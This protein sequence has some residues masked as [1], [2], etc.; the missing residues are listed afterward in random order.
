MV[1]A[2]ADPRLPA[3]SRRAS[4]VTGALLNVETDGG[5]RGSVAGLASTGPMAC[6]EGGRTRMR[7]PRVN[8]WSRDVS[9]PDMP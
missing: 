2:S 9:I 5:D 1:V 4:S 8:P 3:V 6:S 7:P